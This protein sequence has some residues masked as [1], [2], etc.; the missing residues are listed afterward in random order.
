MSGL[1]IQVTE[2]EPQDFFGRSAESE[3]K[4]VAHEMDRDVNYFFQ[5]V[6]RG[7]AGNSQV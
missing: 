5:H 2:T 3:K 7:R 6:L 4:H 1:L